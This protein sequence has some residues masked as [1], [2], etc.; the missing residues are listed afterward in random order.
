MP[1]DSANLLNILRQRRWQ[2][3]LRSFFHRIASLIASPQEEVTA[4]VSIPQPQTLP[5]LEVL[6]LFNVEEAV[7]LN[8]EEDIDEM[9]R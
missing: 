7:P 8:H 2:V 5:S 4:I 9:R 6:Y 3:Q 1:K